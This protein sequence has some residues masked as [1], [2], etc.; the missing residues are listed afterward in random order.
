MSEAQ[1][2][3]YREKQLKKGVLVHNPKLEGITP[4]E[5][6]NELRVLGYEGELIFRE[7]KVH[8]IKI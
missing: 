8:K 7:V 4:Q 5:L 6:M 2:R 1:K 3:R